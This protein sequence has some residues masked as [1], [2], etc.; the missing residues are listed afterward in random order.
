MTGL[1]Y[2][3]DTNIVSDMIRNPRGKVV[4][5]IADVGEEGL[6]VSVIVAA[7][8]RYG[9]AKARSPRLSTLVEGVLSRL[10]VVRYDAPADRHY[11]S[12]RAELEAAGEPIG[13]NDLFIAAHAV[14]LGLP[15]VI[16]DVGELSRIPGLKVENWLV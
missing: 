5:R 14:T 12:L 16:D 11:G 2:M 15:L 13:Q 4:R 6:S 10:V 7:E 1:R 3:L 9:T 8:L